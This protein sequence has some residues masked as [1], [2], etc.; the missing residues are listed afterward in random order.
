MNSSDLQTQLEKYHCASYGWALNCCSRDISEA[1]S[2]LQSVYLKI[3]EGKARYDGRSEF[4]TWLFAVIRKTA[5]DARRWHFLN[6]L[7]LSRYKENV[8]HKTKAY[9]YDE[10]IP[11]VNNPVKKEYSKI[12]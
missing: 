5:A 9:D 4:K 2:V 11:P 3:L 12:N 10:K 7:R 8:T 6:R 1:E